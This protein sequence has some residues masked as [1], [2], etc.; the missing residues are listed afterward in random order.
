MLLSLAGIPLTAGFIGK[1][2]LVAAGIGATLWPLVLVLI[3]SS[4][5]GLYYYLRVIVIMFTRSP[6]AITT[7]ASL[8]ALSPASRVVLAVLTVLLIVLGTYPAPF[9]QL[10]QSLASSL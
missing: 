1:F 9:L 7:D 3:V 2:Y 8:P 10:L 6:Q 5:I 4:T